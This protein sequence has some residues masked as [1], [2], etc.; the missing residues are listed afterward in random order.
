LCLG[1]GA[2]I[3]YKKGVVMSANWYGKTASFVTLFSLLAI[4][5]L[6]L[7]QNFMLILVY[8]TVVFNL[9]AIIAYIS[10]YSDTM[11]KIGTNKE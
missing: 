5:V 9:I 3:L 10:T 7:P 11:K 2:T 8:I 6:N 4:L 1:I